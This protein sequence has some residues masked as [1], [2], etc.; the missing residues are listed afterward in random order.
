MRPVFAAAVDLAQ[1]RDRIEFAVLVRVSDTI[2]TMIAALLILHEVERVEGPEQTM[3]T[4]D[5]QRQ[6]LHLRLVA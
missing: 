5:L 6:R 1:Q 3:R 2:Q 4:F